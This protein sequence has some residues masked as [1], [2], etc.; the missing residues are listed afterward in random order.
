MLYFPLNDKDFHPMELRAMGNL[1]TYGK[2]Y[3]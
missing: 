3:V 2:P 1:I